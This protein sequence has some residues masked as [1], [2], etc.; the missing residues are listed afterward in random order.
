LTCTPA[1]H[2]QKDGFS[3]FLSGHLAPLL[4]GKAN[5][6][7]FQP[8]FP[9]LKTYGLQEGRLVAFALLCLWGSHPSSGCGA[10]YEPQLKSMICLMQNIRR[11]RTKGPYQRAAILSTTVVT[12]PVRFQC[13]SQSG[14]VQIMVHSM[15]SIQF[16]AIVTPIPTSCRP[17]PPL[18]FSSATWTKYSNR[19]HQM[20]VPQLSSCLAAIFLD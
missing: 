1:G 10:I 8:L 9:S 6:K 15:V 12:T 20:G 16:G 13:K 7:S 3:L 19:R 11:L 2:G 17:L 4:W 5:H 18:A 14:L